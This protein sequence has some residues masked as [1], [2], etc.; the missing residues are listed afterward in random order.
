MLLEFSQ[1]GSEKYADIKLHENHP[2]G[3][4][5]FDADRNEETDGRFSQFC[6]S[7]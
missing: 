6:E 3:A 7:A 1:Q 4:E 5:L 2:V